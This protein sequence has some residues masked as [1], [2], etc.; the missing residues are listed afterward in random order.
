MMRPGWSDS[1][2]GAGAPASA[3]L[4]PISPAILERPADWPSSVHLTGAWRTAAVAAAAS[5]ELEAFVT[6]GQ[7]VY[8]GF[9][10]MA[11]GD[12]VKRG[13][14]V[15]DGI[16]QQG[17]RT[18]LVTGLGG[19]ELPPELA[20]ADDVLAVRSVDHEA[21]M[22]RAHVAVHHGG[23][24]TIHA[25]TRVATVSVIVPFIAD[26][27]FWGARMHARGLSPEPIPQRRAHGRSDRGGHRERAQLDGKGGACR[28][29]HGRRGRHRRCPRRSREP[30]LS[31]R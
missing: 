26:Q 21:V 7:F 17:L 1:A 24:G 6:G 8:A 3:T 19:V 10:S 18:L 5:P 2:D 27:P 4:M 14:A 11:I 30:A 20:A 13:R 15:V 22:P 25:A 29:N 28:P 9:G 31:Y 12:P 16:R 23:I